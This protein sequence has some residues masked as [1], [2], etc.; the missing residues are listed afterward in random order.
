MLLESTPSPAGRL[1]IG[2]ID[3]IARRPVATVYT[4]LVYPSFASI[5]PQAVAAWAEELG[6][7]VRYL[8]YTGREDLGGFADDLD[9]VFVCAFT[10]AAYLAYAISSRLRAAGVV[11]VLGG[12]HAR[13]YAEDARAHFDYVLGLTDKALVR[14]LLEG[15]APQREQGL[16]LSAARPPADLPGLRARW[17]FLESNHAK[18]LLF[19]GVPILGSLG[20][21]YH[22][23]FCID[24]QFDYRPLPQDQIREDL[25]FLCRQQRR[26]LVIWHDPNFGVRFDE[27]LGLIEAVAEPGTI[28]FVAES[29]LSLLSDARLDALHRNGFVGMIVGIESWFGFNDKTRQGRRSGLDKVE[30]VAEHVNRI[31]RRIPYVQTNFVWG[32]DEDAGP[33]PFELNRRF[34]DLAPAAFPS[35]SVFT[36]YGNATPLGVRLAEKGRVLP[37]PFQFLDTAAIHNVALESYSAA[38]F[39]ARL[40]DAVAYSYSPRATLRRLRS[41]AHPLSSLPRWMNGVRSVE[42]QRRGRYYRD[43]ARRFACDR[44]FQAF[45]AGEGR[46]AP[47]FFR[48]A[49]RA[50]IGPFYELLPAPVRAELEAN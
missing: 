17:R 16:A 45:E 23:S 48:R 11:T 36:A 40:G 9:L 6:H 42:S 4:R 49:V 27:T 25:A 31:A 39:Y 43:L 44:D 18:G 47:G 15:F 13:A 28:R 1:R 21:P 24:S 38:D 33:L 29:S 41:N 26:P 22:C 19:C 2:V 50:E 14:D 37:V 3:L 5:M 32:L 20:C 30:S 12:P 34:V 8:S 46:R 7:E 35:H 10:Q